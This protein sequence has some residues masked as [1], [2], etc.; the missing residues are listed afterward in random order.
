MK[1]FGWLP[2]QIG[3]SMWTAPLADYLTR[4]M[5]S[6]VLPLIGRVAGKNLNYSFCP[7]PELRSYALRLRLRQAPTDRTFR[8][9]EK[10]PSSGRSGLKCLI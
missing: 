2:H 3:G 1:A 8:K 10:L 7:T 6:L 5:K 4:G 9:D